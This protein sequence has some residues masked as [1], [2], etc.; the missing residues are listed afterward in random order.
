[1]PTPKSVTST[2]AMPTTCHPIQLKFP[3]R[4]RPRSF[5]AS[6]KRDLSMPSRKRL[7]QVLRPCTID[8]ARSPCACRSSLPGLWIRMKSDQ[9]QCSGRSTTSITTQS[10]P[11]R[12]SARTW[13]KVHSMQP[14]RQS[15]PRSKSL[16]WVALPKARSHAQF[17]HSQIWSQDGARKSSQLWLKT[18]ALNTA[19]AMKA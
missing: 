2:Q 15:M 1:M 6:M 3:S 4:Q 13:P 7:A 10:R 18:G 5:C 17:R 9:T 11:L 12:C 19:K 16:G 8:H 14:V